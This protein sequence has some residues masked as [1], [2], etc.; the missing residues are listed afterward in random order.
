M[1]TKKIEGN[2]SIDGDLQV[3]GSISA[4]GDIKETFTPVNVVP[5]T[6]TSDYIK[7][8]P[9][10]AKV[11]KINGVLNIIAVFNYQGTATGTININQNFGPGLNIYL[12]KET[13]D[14][15]SANSFSDVVD[16]R[17]INGYQL[18]TPDTLKFGYSL[19]KLASS[20]SQIIYINLWGVP[21]VEQTVSANT[22]GSLRC[23]FNINLND[24]LI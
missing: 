19:V 20:S 6:I 12:D 17:I 16:A 11:S 14:K 7:I 10:V 2:V 4:N 5:L 24:N 21:D 15:I 8:T 13:F 3:N 23:E 22:S 18:Y 1:G 9:I